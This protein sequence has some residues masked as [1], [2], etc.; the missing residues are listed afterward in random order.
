MENDSYYIEDLYSK[1]GTLMLATDPI[2]MKNEYTVVQIG[3]TLITS[4]IEDREK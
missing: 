3:R 2:V 4:R 1:F